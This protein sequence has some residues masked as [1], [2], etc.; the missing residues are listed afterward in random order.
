MCD[1]M[2]GKDAA[3][4]AQVTLHP[5]MLA[6]ARPDQRREWE[7]ALLEVRS[8]KGLRLRAEGLGGEALQMQIRSRPWGFELK[9]RDPSGKVVQ[10]LALRSSELQSSIDEYLEIVERMAPDAADFARARIETL[11]IA[12]RLVHDQSAQRIR[13]LL[14]ESVMLDLEAARRL[15]SLLCL[16]VYKP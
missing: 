10:D 15:F 4:I 3:A 6:T 11:D 5:G 16:I 2:P 7:D 14:S 1:P 9:V 13:R 12:K 8:T